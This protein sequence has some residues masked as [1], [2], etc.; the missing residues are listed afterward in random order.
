M[1]KKT[2]SRETK[3]TSEQDWGVTQMLKGSVMQEEMGNVN[4]EMQILR[5][6]K[7]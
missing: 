3:Q 1:Q 5:K 2:H 7:N 4:G 6:N